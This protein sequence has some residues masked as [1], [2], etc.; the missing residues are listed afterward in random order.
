MDK[1]K[2]KENIFG[3]WEPVTGIFPMQLK[4]KTIDVRLLDSE[5]SLVASSRSNKIIIAKVTISNQEYV[6]TNTA[7]DL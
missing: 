5:K 1:L 4:N 7:W 6:I 2:K 3:F